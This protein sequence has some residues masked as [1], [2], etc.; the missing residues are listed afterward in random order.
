MDK[1]DFLKQRKNY[2][3]GSDI[4]AICGVN[5]FK[6]PADVLLEKVN[7]NIDLTENQYTHWGIALEDVIAKEVAKSFAC[8]VKKVKAKIDKKNKFIANV[9]RIT[10]SPFDGIKSILEIKTAS[11]HSEKKWAKSNENATILDV[12]AEYFYQLQWYLNIY[13]IDYGQIAVLIGGN[14]FRLYNFKRD[15]LLF[16][17]MSEKAKKFI[18]L[19]EKLEEKLLNVEDEKNRDEIINTFLITH[20]SEF[21]KASDVDK[22]SVD[23]EKIKHADDYTYS[24]YNDLKKLKETRKKTDD[25]IEFLEEKIKTY[26]LDASE[27][28]YRNNKIVSF[29]NVDKSS[30]DSKKF[31]AENEE[32]YKNYL[33]TTSYR[34]FKV[35]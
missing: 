17:T 35:L 14:D 7:K 2:V 1:L 6:T 5:P 12:P 34:V 15:E 3:G 20:F 10:I 8:K 18:A 16:E 11:A 33:K 13:K 26:M 30:F 24:L 31:K 27:L 32:T 29:K 23:N 4:G 25:E 19:K 9:D 28:Y 22:I 21:L